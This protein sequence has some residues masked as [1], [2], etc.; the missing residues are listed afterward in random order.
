MNQT[1]IWSICGNKTLPYNSDVRKAVAVNMNEE[2]VAG[3]L[4]GGFCEG[5]DCSYKEELPA[6]STIRL[7]K[8]I[9]SFW[10]WRIQAGRAN[11]W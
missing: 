9:F 2:P 8:N 10:F 4:H 11:N 1:L 7:L 6:Y 3:N 5:R